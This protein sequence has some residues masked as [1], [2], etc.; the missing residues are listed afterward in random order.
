MRLVGVRAKSVRISQGRHRSWGRVSLLVVQEWSKET[1]A[2]FV[3]RNNTKVV[4]TDVISIGARQ[5][6]TE[7][8]KIIGS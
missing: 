8:N 1:D 4:P 2:G 7:T 6:I 5:Q 3:G